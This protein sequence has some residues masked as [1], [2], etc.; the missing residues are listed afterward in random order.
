[1]N[2]LF[3]LFVSG[4][5]AISG[6]ALVSS[7]SAVGPDGKR[8][9]LLLFLQTRKIVTYIPLVQFTSILFT[10]VSKVFLDY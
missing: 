3:V 6:I 5:I 9:S 7:S 4:L 8:D 10:L 1:M 2:K